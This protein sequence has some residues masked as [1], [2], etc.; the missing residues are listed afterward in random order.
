MAAGSTPVGAEDLLM[1]EVA[2]A[3]TACLPRGQPA[4]T[5]GPTTG[6]HANQQ[7][8]LGDD[9]QSNHACHC[10]SFR[11]SSPDVQLSALKHQVR[12]QG[13]YALRILYLCQT[14][15]NSV[16]PSRSQQKVRAAFVVPLVNHLTARCARILIQC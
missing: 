6:Q 11:Q 8:S 14:A 15:Q 9:G 1:R 4:R 12:L 16:R 2:R 10:S 5:S 3:H 7:P 13:E